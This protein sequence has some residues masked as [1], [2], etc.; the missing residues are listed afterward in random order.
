M[1]PPYCSASFSCSRNHSSNKTH[2]EVYREYWNTL[3]EL[4]ILQLLGLFLES[5]FRREGM[6]IA[7]SECEIQRQWSVMYGTEG[8]GLEKAQPW[9]LSLD[10]KEQHYWASQSASVLQLFPLYNEMFSLEIP[11]LLITESNSFLDPWNR[12]PPVRADWKDG[13]TQALPGESLFS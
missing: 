6:T 8:K 7:C 9:L 11:V 3:G 12:E 5:W 10:V 4:H 1:Q 13:D 2:W